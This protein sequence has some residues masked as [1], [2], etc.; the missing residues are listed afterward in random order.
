MSTETTTQATRKITIYSTRGG[1]N[2]IESA[3]TTWGEIKS[4]VEDMYDLDNMSVVENA[5]RTTLGRDDSGLPASEFTIFLKPQKTKSGI[6][7]YLSEKTFREI[8]E[9]M[10]ENTA[11]RKFV[12]NETESK[13]KDVS[14]EGLQ[15]LL[16][17]WEEQEVDEVDSVEAE[18]NQ[19]FN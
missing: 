3:A 12:K 19:L 5:N 6:G 11:F 7:E 14:I 13:W 15:A 2:V 8:A 16:E 18:Y 4:T 1:K 17:D 10:E 9:F